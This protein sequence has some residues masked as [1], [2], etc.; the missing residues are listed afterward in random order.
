MRL[1]SLLASAAFVLVVPLSAAAA[2]VGYRR[3]LYPY[4][5]IP[6]VLAVVLAVSF[7]A[8]FV[9]LSRLRDWER[10]RG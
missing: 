8:V 1:S 7:L 6:I 9:A 5:L 4:A 3:G 10:F 2:Y